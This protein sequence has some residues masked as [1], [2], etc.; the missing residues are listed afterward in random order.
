MYLLKF[1]I[2]SILL[3]PIFLLLFLSL[4]PLFTVP[5]ELIIPYILHVAMLAYL[6]IPTITV[7]I[8]FYNFFSSWIKS[9]WA[10]KTA[11]GILAISGIIATFYLLPD[12]SLMQPGDNLVKSS[13]ALALAITLSSLLYKIE[14]RTSANRSQFKF[15]KRKLVKA[16]LVVFVVAVLATNLVPFFSVWNWYHYTTRDG[17]FTFDQFD[18]K[19]RNFEMMDR[20]WN[21]YLLANPKDTTLY[22]TF[23]INPLKFWEWRQYIFSRKYRYPYIS[24]DAV[25][26]ARP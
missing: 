19:Q 26:V 9:T 6:S 2:T 23:A 17:K 14:L 8:L 16:L 5:S 7:S 22:R 25:R 20:L 11:I 1:W 21:D 4:S 18:A 24:Q 10:L 3:Y 12:A 13:V 15:P